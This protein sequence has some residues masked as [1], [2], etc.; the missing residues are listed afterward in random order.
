MNIQNYLTSMVKNQVS[1]A[2]M[3]TITS[4]L[5]STI[6]NPDISFT[7][8]LLMYLCTYAPNYMKKTHPVIY[9]EISEA[10]KSSH[11]S[12]NEVRSSVTSHL[13]EAWH[14]AIPSK[15]MTII[16]GT[17]ISMDVTVPQNP[18]AD[19]GGTVT[20]CEIAIS[21]PFHMRVIDDIQ[22]ISR[23]VDNLTDVRP[24]GSTY[25]NGVTSICMT[26]ASDPG[27]LPP[28]HQQMV[29]GTTDIICKSMESIFFKGKDS[30]ISSLDK[31][32][33]NYNRYVSSGIRKSYGVLLYG[34]PGTGK[35]TI[36]A[37]I[38]AR[39][40]YPLIKIS[41][42]GLEVDQLERLIRS[43]CSSSGVVL[44]DDCDS[45][46]EVKDTNGN[47]IYRDILLRTLD[48]LYC[49]G[50]NPVIFVLT[51]NFIDKID[52]AIQRPGRIDYKLHVGNIHR[53]D[54]DGMCKYFR[55]S[56]LDE[57]IEILKEKNPEALNRLENLDEEGVN[58]SWLQSTIV[59]VI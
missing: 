3:N 20:K 35:S 52:P 27:D 19:D 17:V 42:G 8:G 53:E 5:K 49:N 4:S 30:L 12:E 36:A 54:A 45:M 51:T 32:K 58:P 28:S 18:H 43:C 16:Y 31:F 37:G 50:I 23:W 39:Y 24:V 38:A 22:K 10:V 47:L 46:M 44:F 21:G 57:L 40:S 9:K 11:S 1:S 25:A 7:Y 15:I 59:E 55:L 6:V 2:V 26:N 56:G 41:W 33:L 48:G 13:R 29:G 34:D 14:G